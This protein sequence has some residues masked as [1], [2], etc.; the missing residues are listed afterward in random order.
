MSDGESQ[1]NLREWEW[2]LAQ[3]V[4]RE[5]GVAAPLEERDETTIR[6]LEAQLETLVDQ[7]RQPPPVDD[8]A[9]ESGCRRAI[10][11]V[12]QIPEQGEPSP[13]AAE[14]GSI[15][16]Y[17]LVSR[18]RQGG[19]GTVYQAVHTKLQRQVAIKV[20]PKFRMR[21]AAAVARFEREM[22]ALG[23]LSHRNIVAATDAGEADGMQYL[24]MEYVDGL[25]LSLL[26]RRVGP[27]AIA[28]ACEIVRQASDG[29]AE[30][31][32]Q[33]IV[34]RD[35]KP[36]NLILVEDRERESATV[37]VL[38]FGLARLAAEFADDD[39]TSS[40]Q[41]MGTLK[42]MAPEQC[43]NSRDVDERADVYSLGATLYRL[44]CGQAPFSGAR[45]DSPPALVVALAQELPEGLPTLRGD[46]PA[47]LVAIVESAMAKDP[48][49]RCAT[50]RKLSELLAP[51]SRGAQLGK[52]LASARAAEHAPEKSLSLYTPSSA[53]AL[54]S[55]P[56]VAATKLNVWW[57]AVLA[58][59]AVIGL[60]WLASGTRFP[61]TPPGQ[62][63]Q[64]QAAAP[65]P[66]IDPIQQSR[67]V[68]AWTLER[69]NA[70]VF[71][72]LQRGEQIELKAGDALPA[73]PFQL[74]AVNLD[75]DAALRDKDL[76]RFD[77]LPQLTSLG[78]SHTKIGNEGVKRLGHLPALENLFV[79]E[80]LVGDPGV[81]ALKEFPQLTLLQAYDT[82]IT[83]RGLRQ[84]AAGNPKL[85][86][87]SL[88]DCPIT[89]KGLAALAPL[90]Q[91]RLL[92]VD[93]TGVTAAGV[94][95]LQRALPDCE[96][97]SDFSAAEIE[98]ASE[99]L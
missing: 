22:Q 15:G 80:T 18:L 32:R 91:L 89:D 90:K 76:A 81:A 46:L 60:V 20:L 54:P 45:Y 34:H 68:A 96:I 25:D 95:R 17:R 35:I 36:S 48:A 4:R 61:A 38:D 27:L 6:D 28:D 37:K 63:A 88:V 8:F 62:D 5:E 7:I 16:P 64:G 74:V 14:L 79:V 72:K 75:G 31:H 39:L 52:L 29:V 84:I 56:Q 65:N 3:L 50:P 2:V 1:G 9:E 42:Y 26:A 67:E 12:E 44:L 59:G 73:A 47:A 55:S 86:E 99:N 69:K 93:R 78:L 43:T 53:S 77:Q 97:R 51:W 41:I 33:G 92:A 24:V 71:V 83:D 58:A 57:V 85:V 11:L 21:D 94:A 82:K 66:A 19:M 70:R 13:T 23:G 40:G 30:A 49:K 87:L 10:E 98:A